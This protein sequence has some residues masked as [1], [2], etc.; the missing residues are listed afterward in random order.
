MRYSNIYSSTPLDD[1]DVETEGMFVAFH[2]DLDG[3]K[4]IYVISADGANLRN[5]I[6]N[7]AYEQYP[8]WLPK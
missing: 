8:L 1:L 6:H 2:L 7:N 5:V 4:D 3:K